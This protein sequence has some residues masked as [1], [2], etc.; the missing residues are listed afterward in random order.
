MKKQVAITPLYAAPEKGAFAQW[1]PGTELPRQLLVLRAGDNPSTKG[2]FKVTDLTASNFDRVQ[3]EKGRDR[4]TIDFEHNTL[5]GTPAY[6]ESSEPRAVAGRGVA[7]VTPL[8]IEVCDIEWTDEGRRMAANYGDL[9]PAPYHLEDGQVVGMHSVALVRNGAI[10]DL[11][12]CSAGGDLELEQ[13]Q[14]EPDEMKVLL[15]ALSV[16]KLIP[17]NGT[18]DD[19]VLLLTG[20]TTRLA[21]AEEALKTAGEAKIVALTAD[22]AALK[23]AGEEKVTALTAQVDGLK[24]DLLKQQKD[25]LLDLARYEGKVVPLTAEAI[26]ALS[27]EDLRTQIAA[28]KPTVPL[29]QRTIVTPAGADGKN[30]KGYTEEQERVARACGIDPEKVNWK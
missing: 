5:P 29:E 26:T 15:T 20:L 17:E 2:V 13:T 8:G 28:I 25:H 18:E 27:I 3:R 19:V 22:L 12:F 11:S 7:K 9:S 10:Y 30:A 16:A 14:Q 4:V 23:T 6:K 24:V 21:T 1:K